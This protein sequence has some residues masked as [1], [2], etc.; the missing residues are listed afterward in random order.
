MSEINE[1]AFNETSNSTTADEQR[2]FVSSLFAQIFWS[3]LFGAMVVCAIIGNLAVICIILSHRRMRTKTNIFLFNLSFADLLMA[4]FNAMF[5]FVF[6]LNSHWSFG[7]IYCIA[8]NFISYLTVS[9]SVFTIT[10]TSLDRYMAVVHPLK[11]RMSKAKS[12]VVIVLIW[13]M[14]TILSSPPFIYSRT[15]TYTY[16]SGET[17][18]ICTML[19]PDGVPGFS[20][21][22]YISICVD[23]ESLLGF[24]ILETAK[25]N[26]EL[27]CFCSKKEFNYFHASTASYNMN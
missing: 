12:I 1:S 20:Y 15:F 17:R 7:N 21:L 16:S 25:F 19:W 18:T 26:S 11:P 10:V 27:N 4:T 9:C 24:K 5:N 6:M 22:D 3:S 2:P 8:N 14:S 23:L 13:I